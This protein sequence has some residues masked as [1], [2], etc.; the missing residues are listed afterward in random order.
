MN[1]FEDRGNHLPVWFMRQAG[2]YHSHYQNIKKN[3]DFM[4]MCKD[5]NLACEVTLGPIQDFKFNAAIL[6]S[7]LLFPLEQLGM[8]LSYHSGPP[9]LEWHLETPE[10]IKKLKV[11]KPG[12]EFYKFQGDACKLLRQRLPKDVTLLGFVGAP[13]TLY[14]YAVEGSHAGNLVSAKKGLFDGRFEAFTR[15]LIPEVL[16]EMLTQARNGADAVALFDTAA[17]ELSPGDY[18][19]HV[20]PKITQLL[21]AFKSQSPQTKVIYYSKHTQ[22]HHIKALDLS[23]IDVLGVDWRCDLVEIQK[24]LPQRMFVQGNLDPAWLHLPSDLMEKKARAFYQDLRERGLDFSRL[25]AGLGH[26]V[27]IQTPEENVRKLVNLIQ[28]QTLS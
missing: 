11:V 4:T 2:R 1:I 23:L 7:D 28:G 10:D 25:V 21:K 13:F 5:P 3:S 26:G 9:T 6:F 18:K 27:L 16:E 15:I 8:G 12:A 20:V 17:G 19:E 14:T 22:S 24:L